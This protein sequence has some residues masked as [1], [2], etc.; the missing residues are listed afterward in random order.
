MSADV[1]LGAGGG[2]GWLE[3][4]ATRTTAATATPTVTMPAVALTAARGAC[5]RR[6]RNGIRCTVLPCTAGAAP[7]GHSA[8]SSSAAA[9]SRDRPR[10]SQ[11]GPYA[12][13]ATVRSVG[14]EGGRVGRAGGGVLGQPGGHQ[15][16]QRLGHR[17]Q[18]H[19]LGQSCWY[20]TRSTVSPV[21]GGRPV[22]HS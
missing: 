4:L 21:N 6:W 2:A 13:A 14:D 15:R 1:G 12:P 22:R 11:S 17:V 8:A 5:V 19:W 10:S 9:A 16:P 18:R 7:D 3:G 20:S